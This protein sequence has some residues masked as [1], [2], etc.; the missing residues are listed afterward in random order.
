MIYGTPKKLPDG[1]YYLKASGADNGRVMIQLNK[2]KLL[3][4]FDESDEVTIELSQASVDR[5]SGIDAENLSAAKQNSEAWFGKV[6]AEQTLDV[7][8][9]KS[10]QAGGRLNVSKATVKG[11]VVTKVYS[12]DKTIS[13]SSI[14]EADTVCDVILEF[15]GIWF[16]KKT[17][18]AIWRVAQVRMLSPPKKV[19]PDEYLFQDADEE[20]AGGD[21]EEND[22]DY[23]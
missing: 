15:S 19:Y 11:S 2:V 18:G 14:L 13:E 17:F 21:A 22:E 3:T 4:K 5:I 16:M 23:I 10:V 9:T 12:H 6:M 7:A 8:Y 20:E 1:R